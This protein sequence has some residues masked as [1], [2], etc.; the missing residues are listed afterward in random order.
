MISVSFE[1]KLFN[2]AN[3]RFLHNM[4]VTKL[5][6]EILTLYSMQTRSESLFH[7][8]ILTCVMIINIMLT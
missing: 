6:L 3:G 7:D 8:S 5:I 1:D 4:V 2:R